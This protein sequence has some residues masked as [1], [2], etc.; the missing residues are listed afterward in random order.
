M[1][2]SCRMV[3]A[4]RLCFCHNLV[5]QG[6][7]R[8]FMFKYTIRYFIWCST[9]LLL[10]GF[11]WFWSGGIQTWDR[12]DHF[13]SN[14]YPKVKH[15]STEEMQSLFFGGRRFYLFDIRTEEEFAVS[16][17]AGAV[18]AEDGDEVGLPKEAFIIA[19]C[20]VG[21]RSADFIDDLQQHGYQQAYN[22]KGSLFEWAN[23]GYF[24]ERDGQR[25]YVAHP[26]N[27]EWGVLLDKKLHSYKRGEVEE[28]R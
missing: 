17:L 5:L 12:V 24:L 18:R 6:W 20:S 4:G 13:I 28:G 26:Y 9:L 3:T 22:L 16:H 25:T 15:I 7:G 23:K 27:D 10:V 21:V 8:Y 2:L 1:N 11:R 14:K 19:Y